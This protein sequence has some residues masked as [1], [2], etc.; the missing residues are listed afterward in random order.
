[1]TV[2]ESRRWQV[3]D[4]RVTALEAELAAARESR[5][6]AAKSAEY[7]QSRYDDAAARVV[8]AETE[9]DAAVE[10]MKRAA[11]LLNDAA[12]PFGNAREV[13]RLALKP[14]PAAGGDGGKGGGK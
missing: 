9:R 11:W 2:G 13:L 1:M 5:D 14:P 4:N 8:K 6:A 10:A 12:L 3:L 7:W